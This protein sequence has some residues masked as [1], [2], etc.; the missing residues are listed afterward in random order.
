MHDCDAARCC[1]TIGSL[2]Q[3]H[4]L[5]SSCV[6]NVLVFCKLHDDQESPSLNPIEALHDYR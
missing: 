6:D 2:G 1:S 4:L 3:G 5:F